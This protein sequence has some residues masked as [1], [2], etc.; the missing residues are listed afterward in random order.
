M[1][2]IHHIGIV[3]TNIEYILT[4][5]DLD[6]NDSSESYVDQEQGNTLYFLLLTL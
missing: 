4:A 6:I 2:Q 3:S 1:N 5:F